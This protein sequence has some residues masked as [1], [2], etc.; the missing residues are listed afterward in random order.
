MLSKTL[1]TDLN[2]QNG[3]SGRS[4]TMSPNPTL[5]ARS[6][7]P[8]TLRWTWCVALLCLLLGSTTPLPAD[9]LA[10]LYPTRADYEQRFESAVDAVIAAGF[11]LEEDR[12]ALLAY[13]DP[14]RIPG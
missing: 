10:E 13:A 1:I 14:S 2:S 6:R 7:S 4:R 8:R 3:R 5:A 11:V 9:R 12:D